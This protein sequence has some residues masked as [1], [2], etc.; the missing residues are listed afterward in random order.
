[1]TKYFLHASYS[2]TGPHVT[3]LTDTTT[4]VLCYLPLH[5][6]GAFSFTSNNQQVYLMKA[7]IMKSKGPTLPCNRSRA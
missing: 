7:L 2:V 3:T 5:E 4:V 6:S 1:M